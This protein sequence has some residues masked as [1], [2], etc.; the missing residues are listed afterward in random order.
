MTQDPL[1]CVAS[2]ITSATPAE[3]ADKS[4]EISAAA[5]DPV[6]LLIAEGARLDALWIA[7]RTCGDEIFDALPE[8][9][10]KGRVRVS[11]SDSELG[12]SLSGLTGEWFTSEE[13]LRERLSS[14]RRFGRRFAEIVGEDPEADVAEFDREIG[15]DQALAELRAG[16][17]EIK[18]IRE[19]AGCEARYREAEDLGRRVARGHRSDT[20]HKAGYARWRDCD[21]RASML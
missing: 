17:T 10:R 2:W 12:R 13:H 18:A 20:Q 21:A 6:I 19:A 15:L 9:T 7:A 4:Q 5:D 3:A 14:W 16:L 8:D 1:S 11:F